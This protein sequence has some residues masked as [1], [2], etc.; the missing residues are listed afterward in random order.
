MNC[1]HTKNPVPVTLFTWHVA[2]S[3]LRAL[4][5]SIFGLQCL[6]GLP[7]SNYAY[8]LGKAKEPQVM[9]V[10]LAMGLLRMMLTIL[11]DL[12]IQLLVFYDPILPRL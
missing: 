10:V 2:G 6:Q 7:Q 4:K 11:N 12:S 1:S 5:L 3:K 9:V 8:V